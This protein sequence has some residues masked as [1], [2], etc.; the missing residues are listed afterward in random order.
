MPRVSLFTKAGGLKYTRY[1]FMVHGHGRNIKEELLFPCERE[2][3]PLFLVAYNLG[4]D[5]VGP[6]KEV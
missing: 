1:P 3:N 5:F 2:L 6:N 4:K